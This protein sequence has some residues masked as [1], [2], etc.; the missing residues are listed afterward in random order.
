MRCAA[1]H[2]VID[3][4]EDVFCVRLRQPRLDE[5]GIYAVG[6]E[7]NALV[8][9]DG[10]RKMVLSLGPEEPECL[11]SVFLA[12]L[13]TLQRKLH[14]HG[15]ALK[16]VEASPDTLNIFR[17]CKLL[18]WFDFVGDRA[19]AVAALAQN[20]PGRANQPSTGSPVR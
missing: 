8:E 13:V 16:I 7:L 15:G 18:D 5:A 11:Y 4:Q 20:P 14:E 1:H 17:A 10:C 2:L 12:K 6:E 19:T 3:Q 9:R